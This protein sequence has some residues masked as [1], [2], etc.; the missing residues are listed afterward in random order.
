MVAFC[1]LMV[2]LTRS[3]TQSLLFPGQVRGPASVVQRL[4]VSGVLIGCKCLSTRQ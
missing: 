2:L 1:A 3:T 4:H